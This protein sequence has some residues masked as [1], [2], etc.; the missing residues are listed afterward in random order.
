MFFQK[1]LDNTKKSLIPG[2]LP[3]SLKTWKQVPTKSPQP[4]SAN[5]PAKSAKVPA[6]NPKPTE[7]SDPTD[8]AQKPV[9]ALGKMCRLKFSKGG[10]KKN[11]VWFECRF[12][13]I[14][15]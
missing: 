4:K 9:T 3:R 10:G 13:G 12:P 8:V 7:S 15:A 5:V 11:K 14:H 2:F 6:P 1:A